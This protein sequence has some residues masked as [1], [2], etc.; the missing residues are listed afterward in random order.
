MV[1]L[2]FSKA[3]VLQRGQGVR[4]FPL[5]QVFIDLRGIPCVNKDLPN[6]FYRIRHE[7]YP[8]NII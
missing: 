6:S 7:A 2:H 3:V 5:H 4:S 8:W 1:A